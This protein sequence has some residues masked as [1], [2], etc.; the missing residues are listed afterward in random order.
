M[1]VMSAIDLSLVIKPLQLVDIEFLRRSLF[2][3]DPT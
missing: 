3:E 1:R 2:D